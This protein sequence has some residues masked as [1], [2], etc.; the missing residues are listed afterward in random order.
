MIRLVVQADDFGM[1]HAINEGILASMTRGIVT[2][3]TMMPPCPWFDEAAAMARRHALPVGLHCTLTCEWENMRWHPLTPG[4]SLRAGDGGFWRTVEEVQRE[5]DAREAT[6][7]LVAQGE[8]MRDRGLDLRFLDCHMGPT[9]VE[10]FAR[11][12]DHFDRSFI[13]R[14]APRALAFDSMA[15]LSPIPADKKKTWL[16]ERIEGL[17]EGTHF[18]CTHPALAS[19][20]LRAITPEDRENHVWAEANRVSDLEVLCDD[21]VRALIDARGIALVAVGD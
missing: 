1:C 13:Y 5:A 21:E 2:Q 15:M 14:L 11:A 16:M 12:C 20:E 18:L 3:T 19:E 8:R 9:C 7:E 4:A 17:V 10:A 6:D